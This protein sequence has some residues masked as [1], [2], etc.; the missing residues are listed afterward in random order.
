MTLEEEK[1]EL[2]QDEFLWIESVYEQ[3]NGEGKA[4]SRELLVDLWD[5]LSDDF[6]PTNV[7]SNFYVSDTRNDRYQELT[8]LGVFLVD[9]N[10]QLL[11]DTDAVIKE[12]RKQLVAN[13][14]LE[15]VSSARIAESL[16]IQ[17]ERVR[18]IFDYLRD[19][20]NFWSGASSEKDVEGYSKIRLEREGVI[21]EYLS[22]SDIKDQ[23]NKK[24]EKRSNSNRNEFS[25]PE[26]QEEEKEG[27]YKN[28]VF[29]MMHMNEDIPGLEDVKNT[30]KE[31]C[32]KFGL[33]AIRADDIEHQDRITDVI[34][35]H[36]RKSEYLIADLSGS[37]PNV[38]YEIGYAHAMDKKPILYRKKG[39]EIHFDLAIHNVPAYSNITELKSMLINRFEALLGRKLAEG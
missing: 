29:I 30:I 24:L 37:R 6:H 2:T 23:I 5:D 10:N 18:K 19:L 39:T 34:L 3:T 33:K 32:D 12:V 4:N 7:N 36:I 27:I 20:G 8:L 25:I 28:T 13:P 21:I 26:K 14:Q 35:K 17:E 11:N 38:Y 15:E 22:Y 9:P 31:V 1:N 16:S